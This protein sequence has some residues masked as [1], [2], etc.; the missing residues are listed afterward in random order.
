[1]RKEQIE[2]EIEDILEKD[3]ELLDRLNDFQKRTGLSDDGVVTIVDGGNY[4]TGLD[5]PAD[6]EFYLDEN[7]NIEIDKASHQENNLRE[8]LLALTDEKTIESF[9]RLSEHANLSADQVA[10]IASGSSELVSE[11]LEEAALDTK[12]SD[13]GMLQSSRAGLTPDDIVNA[14]KGIG[15]EASASGTDIVGDK[16]MDLFSQY[17]ILTPQEENIEEEHVFGKPRDPMDF[18]DRL[19]AEKPTGRTH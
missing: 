12:L 13:L 17:V 19:N 6:H 10:T 7:G 18:R 15:A 14:L 1:M 9:D 4:G 3:S 16:I 5:W 2:K 11:I 8:S